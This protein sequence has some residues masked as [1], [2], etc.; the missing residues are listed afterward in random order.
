MV[1]LVLGVVV[2]ARGLVEVCVAFGP[3]FAVLD[4]FELR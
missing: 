2:S 1:I 4:E 3:A